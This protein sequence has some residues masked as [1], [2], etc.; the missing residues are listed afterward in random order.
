MVVSESTSPV[1]T[2]SRRWPILVVG[3]LVVAALGVGAWQVVQLRHDVSDLQAQNQRQQVRIVSQQR[4]LNG[5]EG[6]VS[7][8][9][10]GASLGQMQGQIS[11]I[12]GQ[13]SNVE[14]VT[15]ELSTR[16][17]CNVQALKQATVNPDGTIFVPIYC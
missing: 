11:T 3:V 8:S 10:T 7:N 16:I 9:N 4:A 12:Q 6:T 5:L 1:R 2:K 13:I 14:A 17:G 15:T